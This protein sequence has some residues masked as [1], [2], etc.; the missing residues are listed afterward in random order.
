MGTL[1]HL[2]AAGSNETAVN[3]ALD[4]AEAAVARV[5]ALM[6]FHSEDSELTRINRHAHREPQRVSAWTYAVLQRAQRLAQLS[7]GLF[8]VTIAP[9][10]VE[11]GLLPQLCDLPHER[12]D[13]RDIQLLPD[14]TVFFARP[15]LL[16]LGG[17]AK[18]FAVDVA[19]HALRQGGCT[20]GAVNAGGDLRRFGTQA[21]TIYLRRGESLVPVAELRCGAVATSSPNEVG[22]TARAGA[23][24]YIIDPRGGEHWRSAGSV[25]VAA[26]T[27]VVADAL[28]KV[29]ALAGTACQSL[30]ERYGAQ[31]YWD[32]CVSASSRGSTSL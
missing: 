10:L 25:T 19:I 4:A 28:T 32:A 17:I 20:Q 24:G 1:L 16:D 27:C 3:Q 26:P 6:S 29:A 30:L 8:D 12:G 22:S 23:I 31:A 9:L 14:Q 13:W 18:G 5:D 7:D 15:L 21:E 11:Q 2:V